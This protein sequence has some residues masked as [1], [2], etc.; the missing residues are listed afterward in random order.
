MEIHSVLE[1]KST[2]HWSERTLLHDYTGRTACIKAARWM[3]R[4]MGNLL[5]SPGKF[6]RRWSK[7]HERLGETTGPNRLSAHPAVSR[8]RV[9]PFYAG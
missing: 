1:W 2:L 5:Q 4:N 7:L 8:F 6:L 3:M 9:V